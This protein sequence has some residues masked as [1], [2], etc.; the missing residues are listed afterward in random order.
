MPFKVPETILMPPES[1][2]VPLPSLT[3]LPVP[4]LR[5]LLRKSVP[6]PFCWTMTSELFA[7]ICPPSRVAS[8][9]PTFWMAPLVSVSTLLA[10]P[11]FT[12]CEAADGS[13]VREL[14]A[15]VVIPLLQSNGLAAMPAVV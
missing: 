3:R 15:R 7:P 13:K 11:I 6:V 8:L 14:T 4:L 1:C 5:G 10:A 9:A 2:N 12:T